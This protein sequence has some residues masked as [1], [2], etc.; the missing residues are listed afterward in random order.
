MN[1]EALETRSN[2]F[3]KRLPMINHI[4]QYQHV[5]SSSSI[6]TVIPTPG[7]AQSGN[8]SL[9]VLSFVDNSTIAASGGN[10][11]ASST[12]NTGSFVPNATGPSGSIHIGSFNSSEAADS[13]GS[14]NFYVSTS[15]AA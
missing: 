7:M 3:I 1:L 9:I 4:Q 2:V 6:G 13:S 11:M 10:S 14:G 12:V 15:S 8:S 5:N